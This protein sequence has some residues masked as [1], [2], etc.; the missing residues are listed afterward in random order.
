MKK[1]I[2]FLIVLATAASSALTAGPVESSKDVTPVQ[3]APPENPW[4]LPLRLT[5][6]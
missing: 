6:G 4:S 5:A 2:A 1:Q 3:T